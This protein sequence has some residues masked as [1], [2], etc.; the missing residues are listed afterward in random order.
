[1]ARHDI[2]RPI[3]SSLSVLTRGAGPAIVRVSACTR[4]S[5]ESGGDFYDLLPFDEEHLGVF[6]GDVS[7]H[8]PIVG[9]I[10][11]ITRELMRQQARRFGAGAPAAMLVSLNQ[12]L[13]SHLPRNIFV[14]A[15]F[16]IL[17]RPSGA[18]RMVR[19][20]HT[21]PLIVRDG[22]VKEIDSDGIALGLDDGALFRESLETERIV[23]RDGTRLLLYTDG[24]IEAE[25]REEN[26]YGLARLRTSMES[27]AGVHGEEAY[28]AA[29]L[30][31]WRRHL[32]GD[33]PEDDVTVIGLHHAD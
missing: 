12:S 14:T 13:F 15:V 4:P 1:M 28:L 33:P 18:F 22:E 25:D 2:P 29:I 23:F 20:G 3:G 24:L 27:H 9:E 19:A 30:G 5:G 11:A 32:D 31:D 10:G 26:E 7:G 8:G 17:H 21:R 6:I 16:G